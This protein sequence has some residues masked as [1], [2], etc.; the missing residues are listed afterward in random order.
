[1]KSNQSMGFDIGGWLDRLCGC[2]FWGGDARCF[3]GVDS[4]SPCYLVK[5]SVFFS[6]L[7]FQYV[8]RSQYTCVALT[9]V[10]LML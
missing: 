3:V 2:L 10:K 5:S 7:C 1:M 4:G 6:F 8:P 9:W